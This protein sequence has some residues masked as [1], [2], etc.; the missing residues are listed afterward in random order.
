M[1]AM[2]SR[3][4]AGCGCPRFDTENDRE[5]RLERVLGTPFQKLPPC[6]LA[7]HCAPPQCA[8]PLPQDYSR[9]HRDHDFDD[10][11]NIAYLPDK[12]KLNK[13]SASLPFPIKNFLMNSMIKKFSS[14]QYQ[15][16]VRADVFLRVL[17]RFLLARRSHALQVHFLTACGGENGSCYFKNRGTKS[18]R[19]GGVLILCRRQEL[20]LCL[21]FMRVPL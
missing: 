21:N 5:K 3:L 19:L 11:N 18:K 1:A 16:M 10:R 14:P 9:D 8:S 6:H 4:L 13:K 15:N 7:I 12:V 2:N 20:N 17:F